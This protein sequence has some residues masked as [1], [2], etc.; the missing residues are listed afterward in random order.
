MC[1]HILITNF[2]PEKDMGLIFDFADRTHDRDGF[3]YIA[4]L[5][6]GTI[7]TFKSLSVAEFYSELGYAVG[8]HSI[9]DIVIHH[10]TS[11]NGQGVNYAHPFEYQGHYLTHNGVVNVPDK[12]DTLTTNDSE[13]LLHHLVKNGYDT[14]MVSGYFSVFLVTTDSI[15]VIVDD[16]APMFTDGR[17]WSSHK[18]SEHWTKK[19]MVMVDI[20]TMAE[21]PITK[22][23]S[24]YGLDKAGLSLGRYDWN[25]DFDYK[26]QDNLDDFMR[27]LSVNDETDLVSLNE[28]E[29]YFFIKEKAEYLGIKLDNRDILEL[30]EL[31]S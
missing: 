24:D 26:I 8:N 28:H 16:T 25:Y 20:N 15:K 19:E 23:N 18:L 3:G 7:T 6:D 27:F 21:K 22:V 29:K 31:Y 9:K 11:T 1:K 10:R 14:S 13:A 30:I 4:R 12:H 5:T 17:V 2:E